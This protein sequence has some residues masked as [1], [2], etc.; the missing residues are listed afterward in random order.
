MVRLPWFT[1]QGSGFRVQ[2][3]RFISHASEDG[4]WDAALLPR[5]TVSYTDVCHQYLSTGGFSASSYLSPCCLLP[6]FPSTYL[7]TSSHL[8]SSHLISPPSK[9]EFETMMAQRAADFRLDPGLRKHC[10]KDIA[11][12]SGMA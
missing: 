1:V 3:S 5:A 10:K 8:I 2:G 9:T 11:E 4:E 7:S 6:P 12:V